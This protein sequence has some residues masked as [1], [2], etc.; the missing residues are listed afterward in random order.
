MTPNRKSSPRV[1]YGSTVRMRHLRF[2]KKALDQIETIRD[3][4]NRT[5]GANPSVSLCVRLALNMAA[6]KLAN[7]RSLD[8]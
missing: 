7:V 3:F 4:I 2:D 1:P 6:P 8:V 5:T